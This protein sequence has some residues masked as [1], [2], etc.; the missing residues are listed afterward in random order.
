MKYT[1]ESLLSWVVVGN[2][3]GVRGALQAG[4]DPNQ[5]DERGDTPLHHAVWARREKMI[6]LLIEN[7]AKT[8]LR[9]ARGEDVL[10]IAAR[11]DD[12]E[13]LHVIMHAQSA[14]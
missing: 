9:N 12:T 5:P 3:D 10:D 2:I 7:G 13:I 11:R 8:H 6:R 1:K 4:A 14:E